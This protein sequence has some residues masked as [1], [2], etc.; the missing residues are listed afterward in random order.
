[1]MSCQQQDRA[2]AVP[3]TTATMRRDGLVVAEQLAGDP[4]APVV[5]LIRATTESNVGVL[6]VIGQ[7]AAP[8]FRIRHL[9][10][11]TVDANGNVTGS[12]DTHTGADCA[13]PP[14]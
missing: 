14:M 9:V 3:L 5:V 1:M 4:N 7:G 8:D 10:H 13:V 2:A 12:I 6:N 11:V